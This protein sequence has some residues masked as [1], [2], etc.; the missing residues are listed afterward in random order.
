MSEWDNIVEKVNEKEKIKNAPKPPSEPIK[1]LS[2]RI[3][4]QKELKEE[5]WRE[6]N[7]LNNTLKRIDD[8]EYF[9]Y[10]ELYDEMK[11]KYQASKEEE[12]YAL[13]KY[14]M[15]QESVV[16]K[17]LEEKNMEIKGS[18]KKN[19][20]ISESLNQKKLIKKAVKKPTNDSKPKIKGLVIDYDSN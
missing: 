4:E 10:K 11:E 17:P 2:E 6:R 15:D 16:I 1:S 9:H 8:D 18:K 14:K 5:M 3:L 20:S 13:L 7:R 19:T 12:N